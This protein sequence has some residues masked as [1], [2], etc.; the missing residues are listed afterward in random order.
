[1]SKEN[2]MQKLGGLAMAILRVRKA[3]KL[4][5]QNPQMSEKEADIKAKEIIEEELRQMYEDNSEQ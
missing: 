3:E 5:E 2:Q 1:M 4:M